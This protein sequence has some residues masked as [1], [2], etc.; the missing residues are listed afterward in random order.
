MPRRRCDR[1]K[2]RIVEQRGYENQILQYEEVAE[3]RYRPTAC[4][5]EYRMIVVRK[6]VR[7]EKGQQYLFDNTP[8]LFYITNDW[9]SSAAEV[10]FSCNQRCNQEN[11]IEQLKNG[12]RAFRAP[13]DNLVSNGAYMV[14]TALAASTTCCE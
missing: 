1:V 14:M 4:K 9:E 7:V 8:Y 12:T 11:L 13:V 5:R 2:E 3:F 6:H 10:V